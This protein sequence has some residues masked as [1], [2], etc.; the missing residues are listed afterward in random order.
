MENDDDGADIKLDDL[1]DDD[2]ALVGA[3]YDI[4]AGSLA[5][6]TTGVTLG[7]LDNL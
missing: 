1:D 5:A 7:D 2:L 6:N 3:L 4:D